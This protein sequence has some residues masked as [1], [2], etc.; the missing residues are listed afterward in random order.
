MHVYNQ[1]ASKLGLQKHFGEVALKPSRFINR[2]SEK[3]ASNRAIAD[4]PRGKAD[5]VL[6]DEAHLLADAG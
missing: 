4:K 1:I 2:F 3:T 5:V 6:V